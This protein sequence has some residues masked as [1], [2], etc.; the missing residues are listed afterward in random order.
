MVIS[1][2]RERKKNYCLIFGLGVLVLSACRPKVDYFPGGAVQTGVASWYGEDFHG[3]KTSSREVYDMNDLTAAHNTLPF[4]S[5]VMVTN[6]NNGKSVVVRINDRGPFVKNRVID[7]SYAAA[8]AIDMIGSGTAPVR[9]EVL[10]DFSPPMTALRFYVQ[11]GSFV[12][13]KNAE[14]LR[15][16]LSRDF[17]SVAVTSF[18]TSHQVYYRV[19]IRTDSREEGE[20]VARRLSVLGYTAIII[21]D[22]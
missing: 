20:S 12:E 17:S 15:L 10:S 7:L 11:A 18:K 9:I 5:T 2:S 1:K 6:L 8:K 16:E 14:A 4:G 3:K 13:Q 21:E 19:R 22:Q